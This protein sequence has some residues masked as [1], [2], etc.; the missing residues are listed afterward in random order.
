MKVE[1]QN[2]R[3][4]KLVGVLDEASK[5]KIV[6]MSHG[7]TGDK[8]EHGRFVKTAQALVEAGFS[9]LRFDFAGSG[10]SEAE[11]ITVQK[12]V[13][14]LKSAVEFVKSKGYTK[15]GLLGHSLGGLTSVLAY[16]ENIAAMVLWAA[17]TMPRT[18]RRLR[19]EKAKEDFKTKGVTTI[20]NSAGRE[21]T[22]GKDLVTQMESL[23]QSK[24]LSGIKCPVLLVHGEKD[25]VVPVE[26]SKSAINFL[27]NANL[28]IIEGA[29]HDLNKLHKFISMS[30]E[31]FKEHL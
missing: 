7:F 9:V 22:I 29:D 4:L 2:S 27:P 30:T 31:W 23:N 16:D 5:E 25:D 18:P 3:G 14:D 19:T 24:I 21:F 13:E 17:P 11:T 10:E 20:T 26:F 6:I 28:G 1:F 8:D 12:Q 15:I